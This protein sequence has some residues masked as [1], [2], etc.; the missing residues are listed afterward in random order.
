MGV[1]QTLADYAIP[2]SLFV[3]LVFGYAYLHF[4][5]R[6]TARDLRDHKE[7]TKKDFAEAKEQTKRDIAAVEARMEK[8]HSEDLD[9]MREIRDNVQELVRRQ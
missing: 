4:Q 8:R 5:A 3:S 2:I 6:Q 7:K 9:M 1:L